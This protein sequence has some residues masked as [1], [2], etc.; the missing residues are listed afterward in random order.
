MRF[1][2]AILET[3]PRRDVTQHCRRCRREPP[4]EG[5]TCCEGCARKV[6]EESAARRQA[7]RAAGLCLV[8]VSQ[9]APGRVHC[10]HHLEYYAAR[11]RA[12]SVGQSS[13]GPL[14]DR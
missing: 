10:T 6:R 4:A 1:S 13:I 2:G 9:A 11:A 14:H 5:R 8:C 3:M 12:R 7:H